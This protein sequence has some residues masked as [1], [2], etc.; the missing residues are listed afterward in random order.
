MISKVVSGVPVGQA[1][2]SIIQ[3]QRVNANSYLFSSP[4]RCPI[5]GTATLVSRSGSHFFKFHS[6]PL[7]SYTA[8]LSSSSSFWAAWSAPLNHFTSL[9]NIQKQPSPR[10]DLHLGLALS[11]QLSLMSSQECQKNKARIL[12]FL[13]H[14]QHTTGDCGKSVIA[15]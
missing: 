9:W 2:Y 14:M 8:S 3:S 15:A 6:I 1:W 12:V 10:S 11:W 13:Q 7:S 4:P 5:A